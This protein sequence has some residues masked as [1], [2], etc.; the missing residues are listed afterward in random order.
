MSKTAGFILA[1]VLFLTT[2]TIAFADG[3]GHI[4][5][6]AF[7][8]SGEF[9]EFVP[10]SFTVP[11]GNCGNVKT[12]EFIPSYDYPNHTGAHWQELAPGSQVASYSAGLFKFTVSETACSPEFVLEGELSD[13]DYYGNWTG[14]E[15]KP[16]D[17]RVLTVTGP[18]KSNNR[19]RLPTD[20][21]QFFYVVVF[22]RYGY[23]HTL[24][25]LTDFASNGNS[26]IQPS[27]AKLVGAIMPN[28]KGYLSKKIFYPN[29]SDHLMKILS[30]YFK[31]SIIYDDQIV[32]LIYQEHYQ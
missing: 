6:K 29:N 15:V 18:G 3:S 22:P 8:M 13:I 24:N 19:L 27:G 10:F 14:M 21:N 30:T 20:D 11:S 23:K 2:S 32:V 25:Q 7:S 12:S 5:R 4:G 9:I 16:E 31:D 17:L 26:G 28:A 1:M